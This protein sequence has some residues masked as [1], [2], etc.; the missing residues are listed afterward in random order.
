MTLLKNI[1]RISAL[2]LLAAGRMLWAQA[3]PGPRNGPPSAGRPLLGLTP[4]ELAYF[5]EGASRFT[6]IDSVTGTQPGAGGI[7]LGP[8]FNLNSCAGCHA[9]PA[10]GGTSPSPTSHQMPQPNPQVAMAAT[11]G[12]ANTVPPFIQANGPVRVARFVRNA[13]G[14]PD[15][16][17]HD[18]FTIAGR[19]DAVGCNIAQPDFATA[20]A[21][22]N[23]IFRIPT[24]TFGGG[25]IEMIPES[26]IVAN[27]A[28]NGPN[29]KQ[30]GI[31]GRV[32]R[33]GNDGT[34]TRFGWKAQNKSLLMFAGEAYN[35]EQ[36]V[37]NDLFPNER[38]ETP[39]CVFNGIA[40]DHFDI[41]ALAGFMRYLAAPQ[42]APPNPSVH[43]GA[44]V[45]AQTGCALCHTPMMQ[46]GKSQSA[47]MTNVPVP[48]YSD[49]ALHN[50]GQGLAD[51]IAQGLAQGNDWR[52]APLWG[53]GQ[54]IFFLHDG[55]TTDL[56]RA[57]DQHASPGSEASNV[58]KAFDA[59][60][61][62][63]KQDLLNFLRSL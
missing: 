4:A 35:V 17:V 8:R 2:A 57:I 10:I 38:D 44:Q 7:G 11:Y 31:G 51:G 47:A 14:S 46:T 54:K 12:A 33:S 30:F 60:P 26:T 34:I 24:A 15:G 18:L 63:A 41:V 29:K 42:P 9:Q 6:E 39:G 20:L 1:S 32:N 28:A 43:N 37:T 55:R 13:D 49:L 21:Q 16:G 22:Q 50:M 36:G 58:V 27:L 45:F 3:D 61:P 48:L 62:Q 53:L 59:L 52:T 25:L 23:V 19:Y 56:L 5:A 40:E